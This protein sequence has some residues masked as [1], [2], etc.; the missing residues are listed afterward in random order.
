MVAMSCFI[1]NASRWC[2]C[3]PS[4]SIGLRRFGRC[5]RSRLTQRQMSCSIEPSIQKTVHLCAPQKTYGLLNVEPVKA[6]AR[7]WQ[8]QE[9]LE[10]SP[11]STQLSKN[12]LRRKRSTSA[13]PHFSQRH[14]FAVGF[15][16]RAWVR[17]WHGVLIRILGGF[18]VT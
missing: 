7:A 2:Q 16:G 14:F 17:E 5:D 18:S 9:E 13:I 6:I 8:W 11:K 12:W 10:S 3:N 1:T 15:F 4:H